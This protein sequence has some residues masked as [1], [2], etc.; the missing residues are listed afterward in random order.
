MTATMSVIAKVSNTGLFTF[1]T[2]FPG[3]VG[4]GPA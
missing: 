4:L 2:S 3:P 1:T